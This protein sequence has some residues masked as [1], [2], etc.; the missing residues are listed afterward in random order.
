MIDTLAEW[1]LFLGLGLPA[2]AYLGYPLILYIVSRFRRKPRYPESS[3]RREGISMVIAAYN[4]EDVIGQKIK[5]SLEQLEPFEDKEIL[6]ASDCSTDRTDSIVQSFGPPVR[7][8]R[9]EKRVGKSALLNLMIKDASYPIIV[10]SDANTFFKK[11]AIKNLLLPF[12]DK[13]VGGVCGRIRLKNVSDWTLSAGE[14]IYWDFESKL[15]EW[16]GRLGKVLGANGGIYAIRKELY[17]DIPIDRLIMD[18]FYVVIKLLSKKKKF[19]YQRN[20]VGEEYTSSP[21]Y[22]EFKRKAR[23]ATANFN[24]LPDLLPSLMPWKG[25]L[26]FSLWSHKIIRW[27]IPLFLLGGLVSNAFLINNHILYLYMMAL[28]VFFYGIGI[29][30][31]LF[32][33]KKGSL[34]MVPTYFVSMNAALLV[35]FFKSLFGRKKPF[36]ERVE[37]S[38]SG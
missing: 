38:G 26:A 12:S 37:R 18:D 13:Q 7:I 28:Q 33:S 10:F 21:K 29:G 22:G 24:L 11:D 17:S 8:L 2:Y 19:I 34:L 1:V 35:G 36:W 31:S 25:W 9:S 23:I 6:I 20:A 16:E 14:S 4:E 3:G 32:A 27:F 30:G 5:N 15:K